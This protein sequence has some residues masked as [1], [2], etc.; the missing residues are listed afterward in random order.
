MQSLRVPGLPRENGEGNR[1]GGVQA[2]RGLVV[3]VDHAVQ[4]E[5]VGQQVLVEIHVVEIGPDLRVV[6]PARQAE[7]HRGE[8]IV[9][10]QM[11]PGKFGEVVEFHDAPCPC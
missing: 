10:R 11:R 3:L 6:V 8:G 2:G 1:T 4:A 7:P 9:G 5:L